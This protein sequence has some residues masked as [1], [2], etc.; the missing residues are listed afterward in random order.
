MLT[1]DPERLIEDEDLD[2]PQTRAGSTDGQMPDDRS[3]E[4][5]VPRETTSV[6]A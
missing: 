6:P 1:Q 3:K 5:R 2:E 4:G